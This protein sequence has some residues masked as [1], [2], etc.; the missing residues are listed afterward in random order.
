MIDRILKGI[1]RVPVLRLIVVIPLGLAL[2]L[3][4]PAVKPPVPKPGH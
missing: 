1:E 2:V 3:K 4:G